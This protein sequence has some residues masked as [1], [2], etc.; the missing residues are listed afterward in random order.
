MNRQMI[1]I[2]SRGLMET[3]IHH[4]L[5]LR[6]LFFY[7]FVFTFLFF[8]SSVSA[9]P[10]WAKKAS[11]SV[12]M[13]K[14]FSDDGTMLSSACGFYVGDNG[15]AV[16]SYAPFK[17]AS[18]ALVVDADGKELTV[19]CLLGANETY[20]VAKFRVAVQKK[21][22]ALSFASTALSIGNQVFLL[23]YRELKKVPR[24]TVRKAEKFNSDFDY[25]TIAMQMSENT[26][27]CPLLNEAG[28]VVGMMQPSVKQ[29]DT[30]NYAVSARFAESLRI[31]GLSINDPV[32]KAT[33]V[34][35]DLP[36]ELDQA[37]LTLYV[38][39]S[40]LDSVSY[41]GLV[42][43]FINRFPSAP[44]GYQYRAQLSYNGNDFAAA[45]RDM[46]QAL[47]VAENKD[48]AHYSY[49]R[50]IH[51]KEIYKADLPYSEWSLDKA[52]QE[53][54]EAY[55]LNAQPTYRHQQALVLYS[56][57]RYGE[58]VNIYQELASSPLRSAELFFE[59]SRC[60]EM[61]ADTLGQLALLDS[62]VAMFSR[63]YLKEAAPFLLTRAQVRLS[64]GRYRDAVNDLNDYEALMKTQVNDHFYYI[65]HQADLGGRLFQQALNDINRAI[66][67]RPDYDLYYAEKASLQIRVGLYD[68]AI[69]TAQECVRVAP[70][71][72]DG[73]LFLGLAQCLKGQ[74]TE[75]VK[76]L[77]R[78]KEL[79][80]PQVDNL[81][82][83]Y[84]K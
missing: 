12:F 40:T 67:L 82:E 9:Q 44:D 23:P 60:C 53:A 29:G 6:F 32:L 66:E 51:Q 74:K 24:G 19:E 16:A 75:G 59:A 64:A 18:K 20:D 68:D 34:K 26:V 31:T 52:L 61:L 39:A 46:E 41:A 54:E 62:A 57:K 58:A 8:Q 50:L 33:K 13:L 55:R 43:D 71:Y 45:Q 7:F 69:Q 78:A 80:D 22:S 83:K 2:V 36:L 27:G 42:T 30:L 37:V 21:V 35:K 47:K 70:E 63:P 10:S 79:G 49:S 73:Y 25:Y 14:T 38:A 15:E 5:P 48:E 4:S 84:S 17:G 3:K 1:T 81:I 76:N 28:E 77:Q 11:K 56:Q 72:S 65:R